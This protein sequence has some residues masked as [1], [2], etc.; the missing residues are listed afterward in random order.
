MAE[1]NEKTAR[2]GA[3]W[4]AAYTRA[5]HEKAVEKSL[6]AK[7]FE[8]FLPLHDVLSQWKDRRKWVQKPLFPGYLFVRTGPDRLGY[9][10]MEKAVVHLVSDAG[11]PVP[12]PDE[13]VHTVRELMTR[14]VPVDPWPHVRKGDRVIVRDG[15]L[16]GL[17]GFFVRRK[18]EAKL[19][20]SVDMLGRSVAA[21]VQ[22]CHVEPIEGRFAHA[23]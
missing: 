5:R 9:V 11:G 21:E 1:A 17:E 15:P 20:V 23:L 19:V 22:A 10:W 18:N 8:V 13:Q 6:A 4:Y 7:G 3:H 16:I 2:D 12:V 14:A